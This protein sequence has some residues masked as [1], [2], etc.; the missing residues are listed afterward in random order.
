MTNHKEELGKLS[1]Q[2]KNVIG[3]AN[4]THAEKDAKLDAI[5]KDMQV[6]SDALTLEA[7]GAALQVNAGADEQGAAV[8]RNFG[9]DQAKSL[10]SQFVSA[11]GYEQFAKNIKANLKHQTFSVEIKATSE[12]GDYVPAGNAPAYDGQGGA[13]L[14]VTRVPGIFEIRTRPLVIEDLLSSGVTS[15]PSIFYVLED[16]WTNA[17]DM[18][19][20]GG[21]KPEMSDSL[22]RVN[23]PVSKVAHTY[24]ST[25]EMVA[26]LQAYRSFLD[27]RLVHGLRLKVQQQLLNG[28]GTLPQ[29][30]GLNNRSG[31]QTTVVAGSLGVDSTAWFDAILDQ[32]TVIRNS[33]FSEPEWILVNPLDW[34][35]LAKAKDDN[36]QYYAGGPFSRAYGN[37]APNVFS[38]WGI[39]VISTLEQTAGTALIGNS[40]DAQVWNRSGI[41]V[42]TTNSDGTDFIHDILTTRAERRLGL[43]VYRPASYGKVTLTA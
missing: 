12:V 17:A 26:D 27:N 21:L 14:D 11:E 9:R 37:S 36:G 40:V 39:P 15:N 20:E 2:I 28:N 4:L 33:G 30:R 24:K 42:E 41:V 29:L 22:V 23:E 10:G 32:V 25:D 35:T 13:L 16:S 31:F 1:A 3:D 19:A 5:G 38:I 34:A 7:K 18:V 6:H 8:S 43:A